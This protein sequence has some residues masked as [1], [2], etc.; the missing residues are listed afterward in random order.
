VRGNTLAL[1][2]DVDASTTF[3]VFAAK[4]VKA[5]TW[6]GK[7]VKTT[8][9]ASG[10]LVGSLNAPN[11]NFSL[12]ALKGWKSKD[13]LPEKKVTYDDSGIAWKVANNTT[14][15]NPTKPYT[16]PVLYVDDY[17]FHTGTSLFR[18]TISGSPTSITLG[19]QGGGAFGFSV[20]LNSVQIGAFLGNV[21][22]G[23]QNV[24]IPVQ[25]TLLQQKGNV[26]LVVMDNTGHELRA[27]ALDPRGILLAT[28]EGGT[29]GTWKIA[30]TA[31]G[32]ANID[33]IRGPLAEGGLTSERL[34]WHL[35]GFDTSKWASASPSIGTAGAGV[36]FYRTTAKLAIPSG[37]DV[38]IA[39]TLN[40]P[41]GS[42]NSLRAIL[43]INGYNYGLFH[44][45]I[46][47]QVEFPVPTG[48]LDLNGENT[49][50]VS[51]WN[52][53]AVEP[54][55]VEVGWEIAYIHETGYNFGF[56]AKALR[57]GWTEDRLAY[58]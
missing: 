49:I 32:E 30:G 7:P 24:T 6:N 40:V 39:F 10:S 29:F 1:A 42:T 26:L 38:S 13:S 36:T 20:F 33:P 54:A 37:I 41:S 45:Y 31:G 57:P 17:K 12:P 16:I 27:G 47:S 5:I 46:G 11:Q 23:A 25:P 18:T 34:G 2:G 52:Q 48:L 58:T 35:P 22:L 19:L 44:P 21:S 55:R 28:V 4:N 43:W 53:D 56:D 51:V 3:T 14:T 50:A 8:K 9:T 15:P